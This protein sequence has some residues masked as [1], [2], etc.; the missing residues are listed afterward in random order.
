MTNYNEFVESTVGYP[1]AGGWFEIDA[2]WV[3]NKVA[4][5]CRPVNPSG[6]PGYNKKGEGLVWYTWKGQYDSLAAMTMSLKR[7]GL[8]L[9]FPP[10]QS[11]ITC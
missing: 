2:G 11:V 6:F 1:F 7:Q 9:T 8:S 3:C 10:F 4:G 5:V